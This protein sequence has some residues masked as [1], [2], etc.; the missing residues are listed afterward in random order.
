MKRYQPMQ[1][2][3]SFGVAALALSALTMTLAVGV[4]AGFSNA[5][6]TMAARSVRDATWVTIEPAHIDAVGVR[7][8]DVALSP[9]RSAGRRG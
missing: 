3:P 5:D 8:S 1:F 4:P 2:R 9:A 6:S 7:E